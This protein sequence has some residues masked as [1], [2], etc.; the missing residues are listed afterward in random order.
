MEFST[1]VDGELSRLHASIDF[2]ALRSGPDCTS[3]PFLDRFSY[4]SF[5]FDCGDAWLPFWLIRSCTERTL[6]ILC[7]L[8]LKFWYE[9]LL[10]TLFDTSFHQRAIRA[11][12]VKS[13]V[14]AWRQ[15]L[16]RLQSTGIYPEGRKP[17]MVRLPVPLSY[18]VSAKC[19]SS[20]VFRPRELKVFAIETHRRLGAA[21]RGQAPVALFKL[22]DSP[23]RKKHVQSF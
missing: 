20:E 17:L 9:T 3:A 11:I 15:Q 2:S 10:K 19:P 16:H 12:T 14:A 22:S 4:V 21:T 5:A 13:A 23:L 8:G 1:F 7:K 18:F 6:L